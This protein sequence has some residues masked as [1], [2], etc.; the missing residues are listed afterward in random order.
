MR[1]VASGMLA[2]ASFPL[3][4][5]AIT[6]LSPLMARSEDEKHMDPIRSI[7]ELTRRN[8][9]IIAE[10][11]QQAVNVRT[12]GERVADRIAGVV[13]S[14]PFVVGQTLVLVLWIVAN[15]V[16]WANR[17]DPYPFVLLNL[18][19]SF[20]SAYAAPVIMISQNRQAKL[21]ERRHHLDLQVNMLAE[22]E[23]T[24]ILRLLHLLCERSGINVDERRNGKAFQEETKHAEIVKQIQ[25]EIE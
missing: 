19:L 21:N 15:L 17:W 9:A 20:L 16:A 23:T 24:E 3:N 6:G 7:E 11:E 14:W 18:C 8:V 10:M 4:W 13:G 22:Q 12:R 1:T 25:G 5:M 2:A